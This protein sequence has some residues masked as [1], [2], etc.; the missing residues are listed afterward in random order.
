MRAPANRSWLDRSAVPCLARWDRNRMGDR[1]VQIVVRECYA[2]DGYFVRH[3]FCYSSSVSIVKRGLRT[4]A[5]RRRVFRAVS[6]L[7]F[8]ATKL[9]QRIFLGESAQGNSRNW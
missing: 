7:E 5:T 4:N 9:I 3:R 8:R 2:D 1:C 6:T